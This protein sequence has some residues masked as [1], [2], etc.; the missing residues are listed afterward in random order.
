MKK[1]FSISTLTFL[2]VFIIAA[3]LRLYR[4]EAFV[5]FLGD[6]GRDA[7]IIKRLITLEHLTAIGAPSSIGQVFLGPFYYYLVAPF[8]PLFNF[9]P[10]GL[11]FAVA[12][13][14]LMGFTAAYVVI[15][16]E[17]NAVV[18]ILFSVLLA[19][20]FV[21]IDL[22][23]YS[24]NPNL[25]PLFAFFT[26]FFWHKTLQSK[27]WYFAVL[28]G[29][30]FSCSFQ[31]HHLAILMALPVVISLIIYII[32]Y[33]FPLITVKHLALS[34]VG[35]LI[36][37]S[38]LLLFDIKN[39]FLNTGNLIKTFTEGSILTDTTLQKSV[40]DRILDT[41]TALTQHTLNVQL[42]PVMALMLFIGFCLG[43][44]VLYLKTKNELLKLHILN[45]TLFT[46][47]FGVLNSARHPHYFGVVYYSIFLVLGYLLYLLYQQKVLRFTLGPLF[48]LGYIY[49]NAQ[50]YYFFFKEPNYQMRDAEKIANSIIPYIKETPYQIVPLPIAI[51]DG[52]IRYFLEVNGPRPLPYDSPEEG[53]E[54]FVMCFYGENCKIIGNPQWQIASFSNPKIDTI[55]KLELVTIYKLVHEKQ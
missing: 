38:P 10:V 6:Q 34:A 3:I 55:W 41:V 8:L 9:H 19:F 1:L 35:F 12:F 4:F 51:T 17:V 32:K 2:V 50:N 46:L 27:K 26:L 23:R 33:K 16:K 37:Y 36:I 52:H 44:A 15:K 21:N 28:F 14:S 20:S 31:L 39:R 18:A 30:F 45:I 47:A 25:L 22:S 40:G 29:V 49:L 11:A 43:M 5:T 53:K 24:W 7:I 42:P 54:L 48:I 13:F